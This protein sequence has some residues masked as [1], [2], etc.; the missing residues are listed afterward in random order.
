MH[1]FAKKSH[2]PGHELLQ[3]L[4]LIA[5]FV[6]D[7]GAFVFKQ[8]AI[9]GIG[10]FFRRHD[11]TQ[12]TSHRIFP[13][14]PDNLNGLVE[15][16][17]AARFR[18]LYCCKKAALGAPFSPADFVGAAFFRSFCSGG[19]ILLHDRKHRVERKVFWAY[20]KTAHMRLS[21]DKWWC[22]NPDLPKPV[23]SANILTEVPW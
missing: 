15:E 10:C 3:V 13:F 18:A 14:F 23:A 21:L 6:H 5:D 4:L 8:Q 12:D 17:V 2:R 9:G 16:S 7:N 11:G 19:K 20:S 1:F 22:I